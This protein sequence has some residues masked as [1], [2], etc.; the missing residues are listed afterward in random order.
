MSHKAIG[1]LVA[2]VGPVAVAVIGAPSLAIG[3]ATVIV[4]T[5]A[6]AA[7][8]LAGY[9]IYRYLSASKGQAALAALG[10][11]EGT[12]WEYLGDGEEVLGPVPFQELL[13][14]AASDQIQPSTKIR[15]VGTSKW[16]EARS[17]G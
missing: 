7:L 11:K 2:Q 14:L 13:A 6:A 3:F 4:A 1:R 15:Q 16:V 9:G 12:M 10:D 5:G 17:G 8:A